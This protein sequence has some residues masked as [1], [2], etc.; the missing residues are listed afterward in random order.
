VEDEYERGVSLK[1]DATLGRDYSEDV[2][3]HIIR[4]NGYD[5]DDTEGNVDGIKE[6]GNFKAPPIK[7]PAQVAAE[8]LKKLQENYQQELRASFG[9][10]SDRSDRRNSFYK[11]TN[12]GTTDGRTFAKFKIEELN[13]K[14]KMGTKQ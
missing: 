12:Q 4:Q 14:K 10:N 11:L 8:K 2:E 9:N 7:S 5:S 1:F 13:E 3:L 6:D